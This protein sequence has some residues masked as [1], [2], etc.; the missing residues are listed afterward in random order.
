LEEKM[1]G[2]ARPGCYFLTAAVGPEE[3]HS[4]E[5]LT[6]EQRAF[7]DTAEDFIN[8]DIVP[9]IDKLE[10]Q[11][12]GLM[13]EKLKKAG[14]LGLL[15]IDVPEEYGGLGLDLATSMLCSEKMAHY[16][17]FSVTHGAHSGI[18][19]V[20]LIYF[21]SD[22][23]KKKYLPKLATG[24]LI[25]AYALTEP[26]S[27]SD[28][29]NAKTKAI[30]VKG[31][32]GEDYYELT[33]SKM[34]ITN[35]SWADLFTVFA[36]VEGTAFTAFLVEASS[37]GLTIGAEEHKLGI[38]GSSTTQVN[39]D[40]V[41]VPAANVLGEI[42]RG[43]KVAFNTLNIGRFKLGVGAVGGCKV[44]LKD[45]VGYAKERVAFNQ[46]ISNFGA[47][48]EKVADMTRRIYGLESMCCRIGGY[49]DLTLK[50][51]DS[52]DADYLAKAMDIIEEYSIED[53]IIK[54]VGSETLDFVCDEA[55]QIHGG[56]G[57]SQEYGVERHYR[58]SRV[59]R[60]FEGTNEVNR[61]LIP[62]TLLK[63]TMKGEIALFERIQKVTA[64]VELPKSE[65][66]EVGS[67]G[68]H[69]FFVEASKRVFLFTANAAIQRYMTTIKDEQEI[70]LALADQLSAAF[71]ADSVLARAS[72]WPGKGQDAILTTVVAEAYASIMAIARRLAPSI[73]SGKALEK[74]HLALDKLDYRCNA[75]LRA[76]KRAIAEV[77][78]EAG[79]WPF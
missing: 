67:E 64:E 49:K 63:R 18:G 42:G 62:G 31:D 53:S 11:E 10:K 19:T 21:G 2:Q 56:Y 32:D 50:T 34:W 57:F 13:V 61:M 37:P 16:A 24:E 15:M 65:V 77:T 54:V 26:S 7:A 75:D 5:F 74:H 45:A 8:R 76:A 9:N 17:S 72:R 41:R 43:H 73:A 36:K 1:A 40:A 71:E 78:I 23:Q 29:M 69:A 30:P 39:F 38:K 52:D 12:P 51:L 47:I 55:L 3:V 70:L 20:P 60:I 22:A 33:G 14:K 66:P 59:N 44:I 27:G 28:A 35:G 48:R 4:P 68:W 25:G 58:D 79:G 6:D 46:P